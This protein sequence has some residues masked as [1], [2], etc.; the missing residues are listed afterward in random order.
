MSVRIFNKKWKRML[1]ANNDPKDFIILKPYAFDT[2]DEK[3]TKDITFQMGVKA[4]D[5]E[6]F[7]TKKQGEAIEA[8][9]AAE[10]KVN[11]PAEKPAKAKAGKKAEKAEE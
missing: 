5:I 4:G 9:A 10:P 6:V 3:Y 2:I 11:V 8:K 7:E 1:V